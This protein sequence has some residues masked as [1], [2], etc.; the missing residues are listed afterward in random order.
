MLIRPFVTGILVVVILL[1]PAVQAAPPANVC[2]KKRQKCCYEWEKCGIVTKTTKKPYDC[3]HR[4]CAKQWV[5]KKIPA[6]Q[7]VGNG[8]T[9]TA[10]DCEGK[11]VTKNVWEDVCNKCNKVE[12]YEYPKFCSKL[13][14]YKHE[15]LDGGKQEA[16]EE[17]V[18]EEGGG[19]LI[20]IEK[21]AHT[22]R[23]Q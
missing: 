1:G 13:H 6:C 8:Y 9:G 17:F 23:E 2:Y 11:F 4:N 20:K 7:L 10:D 19:T 15:V 16:P 5:A 21:D 12:Y 14:C 3:P 22:A 18:D